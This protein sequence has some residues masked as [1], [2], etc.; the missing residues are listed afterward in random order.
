[1]VERESEKDRRTFRLSGE[2]AVADAGAAAQ[3]FAAEQW[4]TQDEGARLSIIAEELV[5]NLYDHAGV[6]PEDE[7]ELSFNVEP[8]GIHLTLIDR[9]PPFDPRTAPQRE[10]PERGGGAGIQIVR[11]WAEIVGY[12]TNP[13]GNR[14]LVVMPVG[15]RG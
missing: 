10:Q 11:A 6:T 4:L 13:E 5:A 12:E 15:L 8:D 1:M 7:I 3:L 2:D 9:S 14:L